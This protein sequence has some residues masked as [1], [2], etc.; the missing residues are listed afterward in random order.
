MTS[1]RPTQDTPADLIARLLTTIRGQF[2]GD[3]TPGQWAMHS[4]FLKRNVVLWPARFMWTK[5]FT[6]PAPRYEAIFRDIFQTIKTRGQT[7]A[8]TFWPGY[9]MHCTQQHWH[10][11]WEEYYDEAKSLRNQVTAAIF[12]IKA[13]PA[14]DRTVEAL[15][16]AHK[17]LTET[18]RKPK[19][20]PHR[21]L[22]FPGL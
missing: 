11:H 2:C 7:Q 15:A 16:L 21:Q 12:G 5:G 1:P 14:E 13:I 18:K 6:I 19:P 8:V 9:L 20:R 4:H 10:H 22:G 3:M 17:V